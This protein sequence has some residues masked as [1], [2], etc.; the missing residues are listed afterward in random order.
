MYYHPVTG[1]FAVS[2]PNLRLVLPENY[3]PNNQGAM[4]ISAPRKKLTPDAI[5]AATAASSSSVAQRTGSLELQQSAEQRTR[6]INGRDVVQETTQAIENTVEMDRI[7]VAELGD[8][9]IRHQPE[10]LRDA[11]HTGRIMVDGKEVAI[12]RYELS[13]DFLEK[14]LRVREHYIARGNSRRAA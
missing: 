12:T 5:A 13:R 9:P 4:S 7:V 14:Q 3:R 11:W 10:R 6:R 2:R 1:K 8:R